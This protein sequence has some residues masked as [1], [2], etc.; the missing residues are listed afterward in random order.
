MRPLS[1]SPYQYPDS[2]Q[3]PCSYD[4]NPDDPFHVSLSVKRIFQFG[5]YVKITLSMLIR[6]TGIVATFFN[7]IDF[8]PDL[9]PDT[10]KWDIGSC[11]NWPLYFCI[12]PLS[13]YKHKTVLQNRF[14]KNAADCKQKQ[15]AHFSIGSYHFTYTIQ[16]G[17]GFMLCL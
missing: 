4:F 1:T 6:T 15:P 9:D 7:I 14:L 16:S 17:M 2:Y 10:E 5:H 12:L 8:Y 3:D 13:S 11:V